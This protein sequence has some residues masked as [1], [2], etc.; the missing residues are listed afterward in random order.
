M[1]KAPLKKIITEKEFLPLIQKASGNFFTIINS[2]KKDSAKLTKSFYTNLSNEADLFEDFLDNHGA[3]E[4][5]AWFYFVELVASIRNFA[6]AGLQLRHVLDR[7]YQYGLGDSKGD[8]ERFHKEAY[9]ALNFI[10]DSV[11]SLFEI[12]KKEAVKNGLKIPK[13]CYVD[14]AFS[15][16]HIS[17]RLPKN[18]N[19]D[20][21]KDEERI[22][23][24]SRR[25]RNVAKLSKELNLERF[26][27]KEE[28]DIPVIPKI[29]DETKI[30]NFKNILQ[31]IQSDYDTYVKNTSLEKND[32]NIP[33]LRGFT[34]ICL[35]LLE[36]LRWLSHF[37]ERHGEEVRPGAIKGEIASIVDRKKGL[38]LII[39]FAFFYSN[40]YLQKG[41]LAA[42]KILSQYTIKA[43]YKL[44]PPKPLGFHA[45]PAGYISLIVN[46]H[47][48]DVFVVVDGKKFNAK[49][50]LRL[51]EA[52]G[53]IADRGYK[54]VTFEGDK[55]ALDDIKI[56]AEHNYCEDCEIPRE[57]NY[58]R[59][60]RNK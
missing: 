58:V 56:L 23:A 50:V 46:E 34:S 19:G 39:N 17:R 4:N 55:R 9:L 33:K 48:T 29:I 54:E 11:L 18:I 57:L 24:L 53:I 22:I 21:L 10:N 41:K 16:I 1:P 14:R 30:Q 47:G 59:I 42:E 32:K 20:D 7:Y 38:D 31:G 35:H 5:R 40:D 27:G 8:A 2:L 36:M 3:R 6:I 49:S 60:L 37:F 51:M 44:P 12:I 45:R 26:Y 43:R 28:I 52:G 25:F 15:E 13:S